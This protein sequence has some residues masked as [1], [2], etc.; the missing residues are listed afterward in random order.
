MLNLSH[1]RVDIDL[2]QPDYESGLRQAIDEARALG[3]SLELA[4]FLTDAA[5]KELQAFAE[6]VEQVKPPVGTYLIFH[7][8]EASHIC[9]MG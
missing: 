6:V 5:E 4:L 1:L 9:P 8:T 2:T 7:K 3:V